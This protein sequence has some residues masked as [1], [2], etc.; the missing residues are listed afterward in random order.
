M[1][2]KIAFDITADCSVKTNIL[3]VELGKDRWDSWET[4][5]WTLNAAGDKGYE[6]RIYNMDKNRTS[7][8]GM[9]ICITT[10]QPC[11]GLKDLCDVEGGKCRYSLSESGNSTFCPVCVVTPSRPPPSP[12]PLR[13]SPP[14]RPRL[15]SAPKPPPP[16]PPAPCEVCATIVIKPPE[17][18]QGPPFTL[19]EAQCQELGTEIA[20]D[21]NNL[22][23]A[24]GARMLEPFTYGTCSPTY[25]PP[26]GSTPAV[27]PYLQVCGAF[28]SDAEGEK[29]PEDDLKPLMESWVIW[30]TQCPVAFTGYAVSV[31]VDSPEGDGCLQGLYTPEACAPLVPASPP[32]IPPASPPASP[33]PPCHVCARVQIKPPN[34]LTGPLFTF[35]P[36]MCQ[37]LG[38]QIAG[39][40][41]NAAADLGA[42]LLEEFVYPGE[43]SPEYL[44]GPPAKYPYVMVCGTFASDAEGEK[45]QAIIADLMPAWISWAT[46]CPVT[47]TGYSAEVIVGDEDARRRPRAHRQSLPARP[48]PLRLLPTSSPP[49]AATPAPAATQTAS[50]PPTA[51]AATPAT[52]ASSS[53][54]P[55]S[56]P[57]LRRPSAPSATATSTAPSTAPSSPTPTPSPSPAS[58]P[59]STSTSSPPATS[60]ATPTSSTSTTPTPSSTAPTT[61][62]PSP[63][64]SATSASSST[65]SATATSITTPTSS[66]STTAST[67]SA[68]STASATS[69]TTAASA[70]PSSTR[71]HP[72]P[73]PPP[74][75]PPP[76]LPPPP[77][78]AATTSNSPAAAAATPA[79]PPATAPSS[80]AA[81]RP[82]ASPAP[83][84]P[85][86]PR[87]RLRLL[88]LRRRRLPLHHRCRR[89]RLHRHRHRRRLRPPP[90]PPLPPDPP[91]PPPYPPS[92]PPPAPA[93]APPPPPPPSP[94]PPNPPNP[95]P[96]PPAPPRPPLPPP[97]P[98]RP[99]PR[100]SPR[101]PRPPPRPPRPSPRPPVP[102]PPS[103]QPPAPPAGCEVCSTVTIQP[104]VTATGEIVNWGN[105]LPSCNESAGIIA[106]LWQ[107]LVDDAGAVMSVRFAYE[108]CSTAYDLDNKIYPFVTVCG[109][110]ATVEES[111][112]ISQ[113]AVDQTLQNVLEA[114]LGGECP[115]DFQG[116]RFQAVIESDN[117]ACLQGSVDQSCSPVPTPTP[118]PSPITMT[119]VCDASTANVP[120]GLTPLA[121]NTSGV[122]QTGARATTMCTTVEGQS[123]TADGSF[124]TRC[125][126]MNFAKIEVLI[127]TECRTSLRRTTIN[128]QQVEWQWA[129]YNTTTLQTS[130][131]KYTMLS[132]L[133]PKPTGT[134]FCWTV[135]AG[136]ACSTP[137]GFCHDGRCQGTIFN[138]DNGCCPVSLL[139]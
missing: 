65:P 5:S 139:T 112:K 13:P 24:Y 90:P 36:R 30:A 92:P 51:S 61:P 18:L 125:C 14:R 94:P 7:F 47:L 115:P 109:T 81:A 39:D 134:T 104:P 34:P 99:P 75:P 120:Y 87:H 91:S 35:T 15:P 1:V 49:L 106:E 6:L 114:L 107:T 82:T 31:V 129:S 132:S 66:T 138:T 68:T 29:V 103:P 62:S 58:T 19:T 137:E 69:P 42:V 46:D 118:P 40:L 136:T 63:S 119:H 3:S 71:P 124:K 89:R 44:P 33:P 86:L 70:T 45:L 27:Y 80:T 12:A 64:P 60:S 131:I 101:P 43:C 96:R 74:P 53:S 26:S 130:A 97:K 102:R 117:E 76:P 2:D 84:P 100:P 78:A 105:K 50:S 108:N 128:D 57:L 126:R 73:P 52:V 17:N 9:P 93:P 8:T 121:V 116:Y 127:R 59:T 20:A 37:D 48:R 85:R 77:A 23:D 4:K 41:N 83:S 25:Q 32:A 110:F 133:V 21:L 88:L 10:T 67:T 123:C 79:A 28:F 22:T 38:E 111:Q 54:S 113:E 95:P 98:P 122:D 135:E 16:S 56:S 55:S 11:M 72:Q